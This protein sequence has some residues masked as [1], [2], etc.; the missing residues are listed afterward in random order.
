MKS[1]QLSSGITRFIVLGTM[2]A[3]L[4]VG[5]AAVGPRH[6]AAAA[7][8]SCAYMLTKATSYKV[9]GDAQHAAGD[10]A[11][12]GRSYETAVAYYTLYNSTCF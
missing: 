5:S 1:R 7:A 4:F 10:Y 11:A 2:A 12:A 6:E 3:S 8:S 9:A